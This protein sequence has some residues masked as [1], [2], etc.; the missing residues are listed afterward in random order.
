MSSLSAPSD[1]EKD[2]YQFQLAPTSGDGPDFGQLKA[3]FDN[4][5]VNNQSF[6]DQAYNNYFVRYALWN[7]QSADGKKHSRDGYAAKPVPWDGASDLRVYLVDEAICTKVAMLR[8]AFKRANL[9]AVPVNGHDLKR[10]RIVSDF[11]RWLKESQMP[12]IDR[13]IELLANYVQEKGVGAMGVFWETKQEKTLAT[14]TL[15]ALQKQFPQVN[16]I[17]LLSDPEGYDQVSAIFEEQLGVSGKKAKKMCREL[18]TNGTTT[19]PVN[20]RKVSRPVMRAFNLDEEL[21]IPS[22]T[23]DSESATG[24]FRI[25]YFTPEQLRAFVES[26]GWDADWVEEAIKKVRGKLISLS[27]SEYMQPISRSFIYQQQ[28]FTDRIGVVYAYQRLSDEDGIPGIYLTIFN[29]MLGPDT[30]QKGYAK[31]GLLEYAHGQYPFV[32]F[33]REYLSRRLHDSRG[34]PEPGKPWQDAIKAHKDS[35][36]D[37]ASIAII[38]P[39][40]FPAGRPPTR[41]GPA[42][43]IPERRPG[44]YHFIDRPSSD[45]LTEQSEMLLREDFKDYCG[46]ASKE[47]DPQKATAKTQNEIDKFLYGLSQ[48]FKQVWSL[49]QQYGDDQVYFRV[50]GL[51]TADPQVMTKAEPSEDYSIYLK[52]DVQATNPEQM[53][54]KWKA[55]VDGISMLDR[56]G[57]VKFDEALQAYLESVDPAIAERILDASGENQQKILEDEQRD[58]TNIYAGWNVPLKPTTPPQLA[59]QALQAWMQTPDVQ[60]RYAQDKNFKERVDARAKM[61]QFQQSQQQNKVIGR[62][63]AVMPQQPLVPNA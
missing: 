9:I 35:R 45:P 21:I 57:T 25:Q 34:L 47:G 6:K 26:D 43:Q 1:Y 52:F 53:E 44:E 38:P 7:G 13:E 48:A 54:A 33:R 22:D 20:G 10:A 23:A 29:P 58:L 40:G 8:M 4:A 3:A 59:M 55:I 50:S 46:F 28:R 60:Q 51:Q 39:I 19:A 37:A 49:W 5:V 56:N 42:V 11:L 32:I 61:V 2:A 31:T 17:Q 30:M 18:L 24:M 63:G 41:W 16:I 62:Q 27:P 15:D 12:D 14:V 36:I